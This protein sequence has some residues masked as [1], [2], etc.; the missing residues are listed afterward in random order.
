M[1]DY[2]ILIRLNTKNSL[3]NESIDILKTISA[4]NKKEGCEQAEQYRQSVVNLFTSFYIDK[5]EVYHAGAA[6]ITSD[7]GEVLLNI[8]DFKP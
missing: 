5:Y 1:N 2:K 7:D 4:K 8:L 3:E 6:L